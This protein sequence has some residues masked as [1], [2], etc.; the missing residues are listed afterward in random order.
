MDKEIIDEIIELN[1]KLK[2]DKDKLSKIILVLEKMNPKIEASSNFKS[3]LKNKLKTI[4]SINNSE[5]I[6]RPFLFLVPLFSLFFIIGSSFY[7]YKDINF[8]EQKDLNF[9]SEEILDSSIMLE[10]QTNNIQND[11]IL[12]PK[13]E[14]TYDES[15]EV[16]KINNNLHKELKINSIIIDENILKNNDTLDKDIVIDNNEVLDEQI[17]EVLWDEIS[18]ENNN[19]DNQSQVLDFFPELYEPTNLEWYIE[20]TI[21]F[22]EYCKNI[23]WKLNI[24]N[25]EKTCLLDNK[26]CLETDY[27]NWVCKFKLKE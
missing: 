10:D 11:I 4:Q 2:K 22:E 16:K 23:S 27:N 7:L 9:K 21:N 19:E 25:E 12:E 15:V 20:K 17:I 14:K 6:K 24:Q 18:I 3:D 8:I 5:T 13:I 1:P 26:I